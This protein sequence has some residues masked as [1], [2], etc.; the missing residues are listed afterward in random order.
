[1]FAMEMYRDKNEKLSKELFDQSRRKEIDSE[2][3]DH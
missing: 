1:M 2:N 3:W